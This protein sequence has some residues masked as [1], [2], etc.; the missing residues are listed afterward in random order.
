MAQILVVDDY[1]VS[2]RVFSTIIRKA[3]HDVLLAGDGR[4]ALDI[5]GQG[6]VDLVLLDIA[7]PDIDGITVLRRVRANP[8]TRGLPIVMITASGD[9]QLQAEAREA[10]A[11]AFLTK[12]ASSAQLTDVLESLLT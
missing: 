4:E 6:G 2:Q 9:D 7:M 3:G 10:G 8:S 1:V 11:N 12:P 5:I